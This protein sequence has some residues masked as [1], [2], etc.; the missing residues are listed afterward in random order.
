MI[1][2]LLENYEEI[3]AK[4]NKFKKVSICSFEPDI[5]LKNTYNVIAITQDGTTNFYVQKQGYADLYF[6]M[7]IANMIP[8][9]GI[10]NEA[11]LD[12][13]LRAENE[14]FWKNGVIIKDNGFVDREK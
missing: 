12:T 9:S 4:I 13:I 14:N 3:P 6:I 5:E 11:I 1:L 8:K 2:T 7:G 10:F